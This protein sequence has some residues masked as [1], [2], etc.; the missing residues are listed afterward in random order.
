[1]ARL[2]SIMAAQSGDS[3]RW[4]WLRGAVF[5]G[6][7]E[8]ESGRARGEKTGERGRVRARCSSSTHAASAQRG[9]DERVELEHRDHAAVATDVVRKMTGKFSRESP[10]FSFSL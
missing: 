3:K 1:M 2:D 9:G 4:P 8:K 10:G 5:G 6:V 7:E